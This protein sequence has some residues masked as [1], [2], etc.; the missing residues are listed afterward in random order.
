MAS[1]PFNPNETVPGNSDL[2]SVYPAAERTFRDIVE[3]WLLYEHGRSGHHSF[4]LNTTAARDG[5]TTWELGSLFYNSEVG[6]LQIVIDTSPSIVWETLSFPSGTRMLFQQTAAPVGWTKVV[7]T[8]YNNVAIRG[9]TGTVGTGG[10]VDF[11]TAFTS[12]TPAGTIGGTSL[13]AAQLPAHRHMAVSSSSSGPGLSSSNAV[14]RQDNFGNNFS[15]TLSGSTSEADIGQTSSTGS[16][17]S[18]TH[19]FTGSAIDLAVKYVDVIVA[20]KD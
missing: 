16:G 3:S 7:D 8:A 2:V 4:P 6:A 5:D 20:V 11:T 17:Q 12:K 1:P 13:T 9:V 18:H 15:Y 14:A 10:S 19:T